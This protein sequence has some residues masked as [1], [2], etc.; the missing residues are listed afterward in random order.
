VWLIVTSLAMP[1]TEFTDSI[2][3]GLEYWQVRTRDMDDRVIA[4]IDGQRQNLFR[5]VR[6]GLI[7]QSAWP[8]AA[9]VALQTV[10]L[11][12]RRLYRAEWIPV[13]QQLLVRCPAENISSK[14]DLL[15]Q[16]G[17]MQRLERRFADASYALGQ[18]EALAQE[19]G[20]AGA[21]ARAYYNLGRLCLDRRQ[22]QESEHYSKAALE[23]LADLQD[24]DPTLLAWTLDTLGRINR[25][26]GDYALAAEFL[27]RRLDAEQAVGDPTG[28]ARALNELANNQRV[29]GDLD[30]AIESLQEAE[31]LLAPTSNELDKTL[32][33]LNLGATYF[34]RDE[35]ALAEQALRQAYSP[36]LR[37]SGN[38][39][40]QATVTVSLG[41]VLLK[42]GRLVEAE[43]YLRL[44]TDL[45]GQVDD[46]MNL[47]NAIGSLGEVLAQKGETSEAI[48]LFDEALAILSKYPDHPWAVGSLKIFEAERTKAMELSEGDDQA[49]DSA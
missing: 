41:N 1:S 30:D 25:A 38:L 20:D 46:D 2:L 33:R 34:D 37:Q 13:L 4:Q 15:I 8:V 29:S 48:Q 11:I 5:A 23:I 32:I 44:S 19:W 39:L 45:W 10:P 17:R 35:W 22:Y 16:L 26:R 42:Q 18:A 27:T 36:Y 31:R 14:F 47:A 3:A 43:S 9:K 12:N 21:T 24:A 49:P 28:M 7:L 6:F 40:R